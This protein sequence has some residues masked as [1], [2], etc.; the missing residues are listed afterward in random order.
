MVVGCVDQK[1]YPPVARIRDIERSRAGSLDDRF[2]DWVGLLSANR[3]GAKYPLQDLY[4]GVAWSAVREIN[5]L[6]TNLDVWV[7]SAGLGLVPLDERAPSYGATFSLGHLD[8]VGE[9]AEDNRQWWLHQ[10]QIGAVKG[11][12]LVPRSISELAEH[13]GGLMVA[14]SA[15]YFD[16]AND[17]VKR[18]LEQSAKTLLVAVGDSAVPFARDRAVRLPV[19]ARLV[20]GGTLVS[21]LNRAL[22]NV[23]RAIPGNFID[24]DDVGDRLR[25]LS[26]ASPALGRIERKQVSDDDVVRYVRHLRAADPRLSATSALARLR[27][28]GFACEQSRFRRI[29]GETIQA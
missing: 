1:A 10:T 9:T 4:R 27:R 28:E 25:M 7:V 24:S 29:F 16:A 17:D 26:G 2:A 22:L 21:L 20:V 13:Y 14:L 5:S 18:S 12:P 6:H 15:T 8:S 19:G 11:G 3:P 23:I